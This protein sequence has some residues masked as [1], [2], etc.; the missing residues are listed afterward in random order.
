MI[1]IDSPGRAFARQAATEAMLLRESE[2][3]LA[4]FL[5]RVRDHAYS[6]NLFPP[7]VQSA[8]TWAVGDMMRDLPVDVQQYMLPVFLEDDLPNDVYDAI[9]EAYVALSMAYATADQRRQLID[10]VIA[11]TAMS[12]LTDSLVAAGYWDGLTETAS[13][14]VKRI[15]RI[16]RTG[17]TG[18]SGRITVTA[19]RLRDYRE[20][21]WVTR[22]DDRVRDTHRRADGQRVPVDQPFI[23]GGFPMMYPGEKTAEFGQTVNCRCVL[24]GV[25]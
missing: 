1:D 12:T 4:R 15:R 16:V 23:I 21:Q 13:V 2:D 10:E 6:G 8:W 22:H 3:M 20:K 18:L 25:K 5:A 14:W 7:Q 24:I 17:A 9:T 11:G 19:I